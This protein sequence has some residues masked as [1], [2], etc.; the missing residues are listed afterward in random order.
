MRKLT[1]V[2]KYGRDIFFLYLFIGFISLLTQIKNLNIKDIRGFFSAYFRH[3]YDYTLNLLNG[4][5]GMYNIGSNLRG[6]KDDIGL[7]AIN[8]FELLII[9]LLVG[10][11]LSIIIGVVIAT[12]KKKKSF[13]SGILMFLSAIPDFI[14]VLLLQIAAIMLN[15]A[16]GADLVNIASYGEKEALF[17]PLA[18]MI[19]IPTVFLIKGVMNDTSLILSEEYIRTAVAKGLTR[20]TVI[21]HHLFSNLLIIIK[22]DLVKMLSISISNLFIVEYLYNIRGIT[23]FLFNWNQYSVW[24]SGFIILVII[25]ILLYLILSLAISAFRRLAVGE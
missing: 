12:N 17:L 15:R 20:F 10:I 14:L 7:Y 13:S 6:I 5:F 11:I 2:L 19:I 1:I 24:M 3:L 22:T 4:N 18:T 23:R 16:A 25:Y 8:S 9:S 21:K